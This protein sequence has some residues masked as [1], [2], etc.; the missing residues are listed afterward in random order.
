MIKFL[1]L[2]VRIICKAFYS[3]YYLVLLICNTCIVQLLLYNL[4]CIFGKIRNN[5][6]YR[7]YTAGIFLINNSFYIL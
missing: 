6:T 3:A 7:S 1:L 5:N 4:Q 2:A